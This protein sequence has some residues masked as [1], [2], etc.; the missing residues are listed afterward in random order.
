MGAVLA[1]LLSS[2]ARPEPSLGA[3]PNAALAADRLAAERGGSPDDYSLVY[4]RAYR[5]PESGEE[6][7]AGKLVDRRT[8]QLHI[9]YRDTAGAV[10]GPRLMAAHRSAALT[11]L[12]AFGRKADP[13]LLQAVQAA[14]AAG[15][16][17]ALPVAVWLEV[18]LDD[19]AAAVAKDHPGVSWIGPRPVSGDIGLLRQVRGEVWEERRRRIAAAAAG[20]ADR[21]AQLD[22]RIGYVSTSAPLVFVDIPAGA[23]ADLA[24]SQ[25][26]ASIGLEQTWDASMSSAGPTIEANWTSGSA[27][28]GTGV[29]VAVVEYHNVRN[30]GDLAGRVAASWS[31][32]GSLAYTGSGSF[33][34]PTWVAGAIA[35]QNATYLGVAPGAVIVS[36]G[37]GGYTPSLTYD[38]RVIA[39]ADWAVSPSGGNA[40][41]VNTS[42]V[43]DTTTGSEEA[44][45]FFDAIAYQD[46]RLPISA[47]GN[48]VNFNSWQVGSPGT[49]YNVLTVGGI[50]DRGTASRSDDRVWYVPGS[51][52][53]NWL[54]QPAAAWNPHG[55]YNKP[56]LVAPAVGVRTA[57]GLAA[58]GTSVATPMVAGVAAQLLASEP[59]LA[60]WPEGA[61]AVLMAAAVHRVRMPNGTYNTDHEG[62]GMASALWTARVGSAGDGPYGGYRVGSMSRGATTIQE[63]Y[64]QPGDRLRVA[65]AWN[66]HA[67][68]PSG[69]SWSDPLSSDLDLRVT[70]PGGAVAGSFTFDN[71]NEFV[72]LSVSVAGTARIEVLPT[73]MDGSSEPFGLAWAK[74][75]DRT[76]PKA[77]LAFPLADE[78]WA[79][80]SVQPELAFSEP[81][82][83]VGTGTLA[84]Q[85][86]GSGVDVPASVQYVPSTRR[87]F[88]RPQVPLAPGEYVVVVRD[89][90][91]DAAA[92]PVPR[93]SWPFSVV[94]E[95]ADVDQSYPSGRWARFVTGTHIGYRLD[96]GGNVVGSKAYRLSHDSSAV[97]DRRARLAGLPGI[98]FHVA[99]GIWEGYWMRESPAMHLGGLIAGDQYA[100]N[101]VMRVMAGTHVG[102]RY[103]TSGKVLGTRSYTLGRASS[104]LV[105][106]RSIINGAW[107]LR[108]V[109]GLWDGYWLKEDPGV[110]L[111]GPMELHD[112]ASRSVLFRAG[113]YTGLSYTD[114]ANVRGQR[115]YALG[116]NSSAPAVAWAIVNGRGAFHISR[117]V[118]AGYWVPESSGVHVP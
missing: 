69:G 34:H 32:S 20:L 45:R 117:G 85:V 44:R 57:N 78:P 46:G 3:D 49:G 2:S 97:V 79:A 36:A 4:E 19:V 91:A 39:A 105:G 43:Q 101:Q 1:L 50:D 31:A 54:D 41:I 84:L 66:S 68:A 42:L 23:V 12:D 89:G 64:V 13:A 93:S 87:A 40:D 81:V 15:S 53:S 107:H 83:G 118:W 29:R 25:Q 96:A 18:D 114:R 6:L 70:L 102:Y 108:V 52:G 75:G 26:I 63:I 62:A 99:S 11:G 21:L 88:I 8:G 74:I 67:V 58:S 76:V 51:N 22:G 98:W 47:A 86:A 115:T 59:V 104:A 80:P 100:S 71:A 28:Q 94:P 72:E 56:N 35:A 16:A 37:T 77:S 10:D 7:W 33:D 65:L 113:T 24:A 82:S 110:F 5:V 111:P 116:R 103:D 92:N 17:K 60:A 109:S 48:Y 27:D 30:T 9:V 73:R 61:R 90:I 112:L 38:R 106:E 95:V 55:D 14:G